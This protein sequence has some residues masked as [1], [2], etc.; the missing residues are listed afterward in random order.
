MTND[1][2][3]FEL[4]PGWAELVKIQT[5]EGETPALLVWVDD[6]DEPELCIQ[7]AFEGIVDLAETTDQ[8]VKEI[9]ET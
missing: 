7:L 4:Q 3:V 8:I 2:K 5:E 6:P 1:E 9:W